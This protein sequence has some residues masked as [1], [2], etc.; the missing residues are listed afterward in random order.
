MHLTLG[1]GICE[2]GR[3]ISSGCVREFLGYIHCSVR[4]EM[5]GKMFNLYD[6]WTTVI[7]SEMSTSNNVNN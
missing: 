2:D 6:M 5:R 3:S 7:E 4:L 1:Y